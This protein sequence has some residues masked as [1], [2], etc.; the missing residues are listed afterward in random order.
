MPKT[1]PA[2]SRLTK[3]C[4]YN[5]EFVPL[6]KKESHIA[7]ERHCCSQVMSDEAVLPDGLSTNWFVPVVMAVMLQNDLAGG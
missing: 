2:T 6:N 1:K 7:S 4:E 5:T 3:V